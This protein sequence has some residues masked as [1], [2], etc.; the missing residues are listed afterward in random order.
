MDKKVVIWL[1]MCFWIIVVPAYT[2]DVL[3]DSISK[4]TQKGS[5]SNV[6]QWPILLDHWSTQIDS[7]KR[8]LSWTRKE[9]DTLFIDSTLVF[10]ADTRQQIERL[11]RLVREARLRE[12]VMQK[13]IGVTDT[14]EVLEVMVHDSIQVQM[15]SLDDTL[16]RVEKGITLLLLDLDYLQTS[17]QRRREE[18]AAMQAT[19]P[20]ERPSRQQVLKTVEKNWIKDGGS[21]AYFELPAWNNRFFVMLLSVLYFYWIFRLGRLS[22]QKPDEL[23][24][25]QNEPIWIPVLKALILFLVLLPF[26][27]FHVPLFV[28]QI[29][30]L[31]IFIFL[32]LILYQELSALKRRVLQLVFIYY[33]ATILANLLL[34]E[35]W[36]TQL[37]A[38]A[39]NISGIFLVWRLGYRTDLNNPIGYLHRYA[40]LAIALGHLLAVACLILGYLHIAR[41]WSLVAAIGFLQVLSLRAFRDMLLHDLKKQHERASPDTWFRRFD[42]K[43]MLASADRLIR[44]CCMLLVVQ[45]ILNGLHLTREA[46]TLFNKLMH[47]PHKIGNITFSY[48]NLLLALLAIGMAN[49]LQ[50]SLKKILDTPGTSE[51]HAQK[52][53]LFPL[54]RVFI[55]VIGFLIGISILGLG[56]DKLTVIIGALSVGIGLGLQNIINNFVSG[57]ILVFEKPFKIGDY[58]ELADKKGQVMQIGIRSSTLLTDQGARVIIPNGD[59]LSGRL[60]NWTFSDSDIRLNMQLLVEKSVNL[61]EWKE[62]LHQKTISFE[63]VDKTIPLK[64]WTQGI[65]SDHYQISIQVGIRHVQLIEKFKS[66]FLEAVQQEMDNRQV[67][68]ASG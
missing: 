6:Q 53:T 61:S 54:L 57:V 44:L 17:A 47:T 22:S 63:E 31:L 34:S 64:I 19:P 33:F 37:M 15:A 43:Q 12:E 13:K 14:S 36:W 56:M 5:E 2:Q 65:T 26:A 59:L 48:G 32:Y 58:V 46:A 60:V 11:G 24:I 49:W 3:T 55:V 21:M 67:K 16:E 41:M 42:L 38:G 39:I 45:V 68:I 27:S 25:H 62:W 50:K 18:L 7:V 10:F 35:I 66:R 9:A 1:L 29:G 28:L 23:R 8:R 20:Q 4:R 51:Q 40:R 52:M 30:Y